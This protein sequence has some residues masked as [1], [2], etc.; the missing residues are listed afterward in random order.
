MTRLKKQN[1]KNSDT[2]LHTYM[3]QRFKLDGRMD[4]DIQ[5]DGKTMCTHVNIVVDALEQLPLSEGVCSQ[6][7]IVT[8]HPEVK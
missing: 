4:V 2:S 7:G 6:L 3:D 5:F 8:Y 1:F